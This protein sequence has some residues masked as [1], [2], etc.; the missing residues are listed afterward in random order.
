MTADRPP[1]LDQITDHLEREQ[2]PFALIGAAALAVHGISRSTL[3][4]DL[5]VCDRRV[6]DDDFWAP[7]AA[8]VVIDIRRGDAVDP[9]AGVV[10]CRADGQRDVDVVVGKHRWQADIIDRADPTRRGNRQVPTARVADLILLKL[11]AGGSQDRWDIEQLLGRGDRE[12]V[13]RTVGERLEALP[14]SAQ[15]MWRTLLDNPGD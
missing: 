9:L 1:L 11:Y 8:T 6:L 5:L 4:I 7:F 13:V 10:R 3:D 14:P 12:T 15:R 2:I